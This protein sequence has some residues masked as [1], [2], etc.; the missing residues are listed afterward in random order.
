VFKL[1]ID[2]LVG[3]VRGQGIPLPTFLPGGRMSVKKICVEEHWGNQDLENIRNNWLKYMGLTVSLDTGL[4]RKILQ[5][6]WAFEERIEIMNKNEIEVQVISL[7]SPGVQG[8]VDRHEAIVKARELNDLQAD[9]IVRFPG[10]FS[11]FA[12]LPLQDPQA[13]ARELERT[14][15]DLKFRGAMVHGH[16]HGDYLDMKRFW[17]IWETAERLGVPIYLHVNEPLRNQLQ[18]LD[19]YPELLG[20]TWSW[21]VETATHALRIISSGVFDAFP[22]AKL[23]LG[24]LGES[25]PFLL[26][27]LD[28]GFAIV[29]G[30]K[31]GRIKGT[32]SEYLRRNVFVTTSGKYHAEAL[33][34]VIEAM[35]IDHV[36]LAI[37]YPFAN[38]EEAIALVD[39][40]A[41]SES[42][43]EKIYHT[44]A[45]LL[46]GL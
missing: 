31:H 7:S 10:R 17:V 6:L 12:T 45:R 35:G 23:I 27:R 25:L 15:I 9:L 40:V 18:I 19:G 22:E 2:E 42:E 46:L 4:R 43:R 8:V 13:A 29:G 11:G 33:R 30:A 36:L 39:G 32:P 24:H 1:G 14:V 5:K 3:R 26:G 21:G 28:E 16:T 34:C 41:L 37:D 20:P 44:N 38:T